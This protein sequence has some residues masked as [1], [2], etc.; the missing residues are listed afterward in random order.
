MDTRILSIPVN[1]GPA[2]FSKEKLLEIFADSYRTPVPPRGAE[3]TFNKIHAIKMARTEFDL[4][5]KD[6]KD[7][8]EAFMEDVFRTNF[9]MNERG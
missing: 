9:Y 6:A 3:K 4:G 7:L 8:V 5:L 2:A 1:V